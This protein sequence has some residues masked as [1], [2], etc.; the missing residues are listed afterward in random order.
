M[1]EFIGL[2]YY[3]ELPGVFFDVQRVGPST[4]MPT[5]T[6]QGDILSAYYLSHGD[7]R[8]IVLLP[9]S[10]EECYE[11]AIEAFNLAERFQTPV[12]VMLDLDLGMNNWMTTPFVY[13][14]KPFDRGKVLDAEALEKIGKFER[15][16]DVDGDGI[17]Y[18][19]LPGTKHPLAAY[20]T[21]G[22]SHDEAAKYSESSETFAR[23]LDRIAKKIDTA[24]N[25]VP[26][27]IECKVD[28]AQLGII[29]Y[30]TT[31]WAVE[32]SLAQLRSEDVKADYLRVRGLP[33]NGKVRSFIEN[34]A[35]V[36]VVEQNQQ[37]QLASLIRSEMSDLSMRIDTILCYDGMPPEA[38]SV[39]API[40][41]SQKEAANV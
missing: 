29:A 2:G 33:L 20:F 17:P 7:T 11:F 27:P 16:R 6:S 22:S 3:A 38:R 8:H 13:P 37:G 35:K 12:F 18:R 1:S 21:R 41:K 5:R 4:G 23:N 25:E 36:F 9:G 15:Y 10:V 39:T 32:E 34:H 30:G 31:H 19:T 24:K 40:I 28:G 14:D 26:Q